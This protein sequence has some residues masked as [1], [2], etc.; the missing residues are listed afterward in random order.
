MDEE[1]LQFCVISAQGVA[2]CCCSVGGVCA[3]SPHR[4]QCCFHVAHSCI[5]EFLL[6]SC[7][8]RVRSFQLAALLVA[9]IT[10]QAVLLLCRAGIPVHQYHAFMSSPFEAALRRDLLLIVRWVCNSSSR[11]VMVVWFCLVFHCVGLAMKR[12]RFPLLTLCEDKHRQGIDIHY[13]NTEPAPLLSVC[14][15]PPAAPCSEPSAD[16]LR[17][18]V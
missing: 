11:L 17:L 7:S 5:V 3:F 2:S 16:P 13:A 9:G 10:K 4:V 18:S 8:A 15:H 6:L 12:H 14:C 1:A